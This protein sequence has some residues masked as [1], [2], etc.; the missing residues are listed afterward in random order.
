MSF[1]KVFSPFIILIKR[2]TVSGVSGWKTHEYCKN[3]SASSL[4][5]VKSLQSP[6]METSETYLCGKERFLQLN[7]TFLDS[8]LFLQCTRPFGYTQWCKHGL[9]LTHVEKMDFIAKTCNHNMYTDMLGFLYLFIYFFVIFRNIQVDISH[10]FL[11]WY[12][13]LFSVLMLYTHKSL[14]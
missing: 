1:A 14:K 2:G 4:W 13:L 12:T 5:Y 6:R 7:E 9:T 10:I 11:F 8:F 3:T